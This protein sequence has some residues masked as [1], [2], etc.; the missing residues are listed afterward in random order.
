MEGILEPFLKN[1]NVLEAMF[2]NRGISLP[3]AATPT[4][5]ATVAP[6][7]GSSSADGTHECRGDSHPT[8]GEDE[9]AREKTSAGTAVKRSQIKEGEGRHC[10]DSSD[11]PGQRD[12]ISGVDQRGS[13][14]GTRKRIRRVA[15]L[16]RT[17]DGEERRKGDGAWSSPPAPDPKACD[18][19]SSCGTGYV[20]NGGDGVG[21][22]GV[23]DML[24]GYRS[25]ITSKGCWQMDAAAAAQGD[26]SVRLGFD[27]VGFDLFID[28]EHQRLER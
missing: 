28:L 20:Q 15:H 26:P 21:Y 8:R 17:E 13:N 3:G 24:H 6:I 4:A 18:N 7:D 10:Q 19:A 2:D 5:F 16:R 23:G 27:S 12:G 9:G 11:D 25:R 14:S 22:G 1:A